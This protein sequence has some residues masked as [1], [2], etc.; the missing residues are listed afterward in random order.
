M[1]K[2][3]Y[4]KGKDRNRSEYLNACKNIIEGRQNEIIKENQG[5]VWLEC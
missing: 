4:K 2:L 1:I 3:L 5:W